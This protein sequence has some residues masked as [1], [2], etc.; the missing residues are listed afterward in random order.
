M[1]TTTVRTVADDAV[2]DADRQR[3]AA[4]AH[5][6]LGALGAPSAPVEVRLVSDAEARR[7]DG[8]LTAAGCATFERIEPASRSKPR[9]KRRVGSDDAAR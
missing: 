6:A 8:R 4:A 7:G 3:V 1:G 2:S 9:S 5:E